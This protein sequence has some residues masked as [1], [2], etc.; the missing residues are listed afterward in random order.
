MHWSWDCGTCIDHH[1][2]TLEGGT[3]HLPAWAWGLLRSICFK[4]G[5]GGERGVGYLS[6][7]ERK[8]WKELRRPF[9]L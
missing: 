6:I 2:W 7:T 4:T 9:D 8:Q 1:D 5:G 3:L